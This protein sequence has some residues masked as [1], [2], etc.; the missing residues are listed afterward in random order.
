M[1]ATSHSN[2]HPGGKVPPGLASWLLQPL[3]RMLPGAGNEHAAAA[4]DPALL[5]MVERVQEASGLWSVHIGTAQDQMRKATDELL[6]G[7]ASILQEL[8]QIVTPATAEHDALTAEDVDARAAMLANSERRLRTLLDHFS[9]FVQ[10]RDSML[11]SVRS[12]SSASDILASMAE[13]VS[14]LA[15]QTNLLSINAAIEA[16]RAGESGRGFSV[17]AG[18]VRRLSSESGST[19]KNISDQVTRF[20]R[21]IHKVLDDADSHARRDADV[22]R[23]SEEIVNDVITQVD[24]AVSGLNA[25][26]AELRERGLTVRAQVEQMMISFQF[27]DRVQQILDQVRRSMSDAA[28]VLLA[29]AI[30]GRVP[31]AAEWSALLSAGYTTD[32]QRVASAGGAAVNL[33]GQTSETTFF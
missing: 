12:L 26:A 23:S 24:G 7:F 25:R 27:Q 1:S 33:G 20:N 5:E 16:A 28:Q 9:S 15:R 32:E 6:M 10:S 8:D 11:G 17:V 14:K 29:A 3:T 30:E 22:V 18:E 2:R 21:H 31:D 13:D 19:G 4:A